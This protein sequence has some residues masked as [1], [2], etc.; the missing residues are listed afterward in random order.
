MMRLIRSLRRAAACESGVAAVEFALAAPILIAL[1]FGGYEVSR[2]ILIQQ[3]TEKMAYAI[4]DVTSQLDVVTADDLTDIFLATEQIM[5]PYAF[6]VDGRA[7][8]TSVH[9]DED[10]NKPTVRWQCKSPSDIA[11]TSKIGNVGGAASLPANLL[12][13]ERD[14]VIVAEVFYNFKPLYKTEYLPAYSLYKTAV[15]RPRLGALTTP[16]GC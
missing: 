10:A 11:V 4:A 9:R 5:L 3:K 6:A 14:G 2:F 15:F 12:I 8:L 7:V 13:D 16:P 1:T